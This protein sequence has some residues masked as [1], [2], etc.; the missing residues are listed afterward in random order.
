M[1]GAAKAWNTLQTE[2]M[3]QMT[4]VTTM[5]PKVPAYADNA[6]ATGDLVFALNANRRG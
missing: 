1:Q 4:G 2:K 3:G 5:T 6:G